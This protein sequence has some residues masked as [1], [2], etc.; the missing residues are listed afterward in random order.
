YW[1]RIR[2]QSSTSNG[3]PCSRAQRRAIESADST[4]GCGS[5][6][7]RG[8]ASKALVVSYKTSPK[9]QHESA[10]K[11]ERTGRANRLSRPVRTARVRKLGTNV[12]SALLHSSCPSQAEGS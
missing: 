7:S 3:D 4:A 9:S 5:L 6:A 11:F 12:V 1:V 10:R 2:S 8:F